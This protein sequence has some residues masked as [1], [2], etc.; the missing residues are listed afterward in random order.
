MTEQAAWLVD[1]V[2]PRVPVRQWVLSMPFKI[3]FIL[4]KSGR[5][6]RE[7][8]NIFLSEVFRA[9]KKRVG[10]RGRTGAVTV[11]QRAGSALNLVRSS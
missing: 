5:L 9:I 8:L 7:V 1:H 2:I 4:A 6:K 10:K 11:V 3:R